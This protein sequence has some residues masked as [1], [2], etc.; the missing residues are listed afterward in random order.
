MVIT[1]K[2]RI[3]PIKNK[4]IHKLQKNKGD[5]HLIENQLIMEEKPQ[6]M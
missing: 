2:A 4:I 6:K 3:M 5:L 1:S